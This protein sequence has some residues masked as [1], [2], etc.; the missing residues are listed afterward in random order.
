MCC[1]SVPGAS[2]PGGY[3][4]LLHLPSLV[5]CEPVSWGC[6]RVTDNTLLPGAYFMSKLYVLL[7]F[8]VIAVC[9]LKMWKTL[10]TYISPHS[11]YTSAF[12]KKKH[13]R[14]NPLCML[15][16]PTS[17]QTDSSDTTQEQHGTLKPCASV[18]AEPRPRFC[19]V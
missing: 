1:V 19:V 11:R 9:T 8:F 7:L 3:R 13:A 14:K 17:Q 18:I 5:V 2:M 15:T 10:R 6:D 4:C 12:M 16:P